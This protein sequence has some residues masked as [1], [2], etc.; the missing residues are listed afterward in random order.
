MSTLR[1][2]DSGP[3]VIT[4]QKRLR[5]AGHGLIAGRKLA[6]DGRF[7]G[8]TDHALRQFQRAGGLIP[9]GIAGPKTWKALN[10]P[11]RKRDPV[12]FGY[13]AG[14]VG[15]SGAQAAQRARTV[16]A[17][18]GGAS[19]PVHLKTS[20]QGIAFIYSLEAAPGRSNILHWPG[21]D[22]SG[23]TLGPGYDMGGRSADEIRAD[24]QAIKISREIA[25][26]VAKAAGLKGEQARQFVKDNARL[27]D[28][29][30]RRD[31]EYDLLQ[32]VVPQ[33]E[34]IVRRAVTIDLY[35]HE[36]DAL[37][38]FAYN[39][40]SISVTAGHLNR[41]EV[42]RAIKLIRS[43]TKSKGLQLAGLVKR[44]EQEVTLYL[45]GD[46]GKLLPIT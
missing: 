12:P 39:V 38:S 31:Q 44:R 24:L 14:L 11:P 10:A 5:E 40:G 3:E 21:G 6:L 26:K 20:A 16:P 30:L 18:R 37:V 33:Y 28:P 1:K 8:D 27:V 22:N 36:F 25:D 45:Y 17:I 32:R 4:L 15:G 23:V 19:A 34:T 43:V 29:A 42:N 46:Y 2:G 13:L 41:G 35:Q 7:G 9:D